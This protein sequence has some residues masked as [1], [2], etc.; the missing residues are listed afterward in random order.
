[1]RSEREESFM[2]N[3][4]S[5]VDQY[6]LLA[7]FNLD[8][9]KVESFEYKKIRNDAG[10]FIRLKRTNEPCPRCG[11]E[12]PQ[13]KDYQTKQIK[14]AVLTDRNCIVYY[15]ARRFI[16]P[17]CKRTYYEHNPFV[18]K[19]QKISALTVTNVLTDLK[20][21]GETFTTIARRYGISPTSVASIFDSHVD[22]KPFPL[23]E[24]INLDECYAFAGEEGKYVLMILDD[25][26]GNPID[27]L[28]S[29]RKD[30]LL[31]YFRM[32][33]EK[34]RKKVKYI[35]TDMYDIYRQ[36][37]HSVFKG[38]IHSCDHYHVSQ[39]I[40]RKL[41][42]VRIRVMNRYAE[43]D[44]LAKKEKKMRKGESSDEYYLLKHFNWL[45][46][47]TDN[48]N[49]EARDQ[50]LYPDR[51]KKYN[52]HFKKNM[53]FAQ[54]LDLILVIDEELTEAYKLKNQFNDFY[55]SSTYQSA[56]E[57]LR[58]L[59]KSFDESS[60]PEMKECSRTLSNWFNEI[61]NSF[62][63]VENE[64]VVHKDTGAVTVLPKHM[65]NATIE[66]KNGILKLIKKAGC[67]YHNW[68]RFRNRSLY[69]LRKDASFLLEPI[70]EPLARQAYKQKN[71][72]V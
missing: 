34:E 54:L 8:E 19:S 53:N 48:P 12:N 22:M 23:S 55:S 27:I 5:P 46:Y 62:I 18:F 58:S 35:C 63:V 7:L 21:P 24:R 31:K 9:E 71:K 68:D 16:C 11:C 50:I 44:R 15:S 51:E 25:K 57:A 66:R 3:R 52:G 2:N 37:I 72:E 42:R 70:D 20:E 36:V 33:P 43:R 59:I 61:I 30:Y 38:S 56:P 28:P 40:H 14:H 17:F 64:Y 67:G 29:R 26:T 1:M 47:V 39:E 6:S 45:L 60:V 32:I 69:C 41:E 10:L 13:I 65:N 49:K 4:S